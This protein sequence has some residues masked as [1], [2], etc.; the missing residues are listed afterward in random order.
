[1]S[2]TRAIS[3]GLG[4]S[5]ESV[6]VVCTNTWGGNVL[7]S[8]AHSSGH[9]QP[10]I[11]WNP[12]DRRF[13]GHVNMHLPDAWGYISFGPPIGDKLVDNVPPKDSTWPARLA[14]MH[15]Y[16]AQVAFKDDGGVYASDVEQLSNLIDPVITAPFNIVISLNDNGGY[17]V[18]VSGNPDGSIV[19]VT[20]ERFISVSPGVIS[21]DS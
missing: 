18:V 20:H 14:A 1:V 4:E 5:F 12:K 17:T 21:K 3:T 6:E 16:Y 10:Q 19:S 15:I 9:R 11:V 13:S 2:K 7:I 8:L